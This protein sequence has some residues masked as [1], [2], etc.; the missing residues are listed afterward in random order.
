MILQGYDLYDIRRR[1]L[2]DHN[3]YL[4]LIETTYWFQSLPYSESVVWLKIL[5]LV[6]RVRRPEFDVARWRHEYGETSMATWPC[7]TKYEY[8]HHRPLLNVAVQV[9]AYLPPNLSR[10]ACT[11][12]VVETVILVLYRIHAWVLCKASLHGLG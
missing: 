12:Q 10:Y 7:P 8:E 6:S 11:A 2:V 9:P 1:H 3:S 5:E 4:V